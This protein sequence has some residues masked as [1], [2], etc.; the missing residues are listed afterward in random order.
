MKKCSVC[1]ETKS[2]SEFY[3]V[4]GSKTRLRAECKICSNKQNAKRQ[5]ENKDERNTY[6]KQWAKENPETGKKAGQKWR[7]NNKG[8]VNAFTAKRRASIRNA[9]LDWLTGDQFKEM[10]Q[11]YTD[12]IYLT[13]L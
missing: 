1:P 13:N 2:E 3:L 4:S 11:F 6:K 12:A 5:L 8:K 10:E 9:T 7:K